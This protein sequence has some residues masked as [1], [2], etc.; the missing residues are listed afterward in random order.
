[1][2]LFPP[3]G[4]I[5][6]P[7]ISFQS[8]V[9]IFPRIIASYFSLFPFTKSCSCPDFSFHKQ[10]SFS[11]LEI[12]HNLLNS[13][14]GLSFKVSSRHQ[15]QSLDN[16]LVLII[17]CMIRRTVSVLACLATVLHYLSD[18]TNYISVNYFIF[19][20]YIHYTSAV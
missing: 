3:S 15:D 9:I 14:S 17:F 6:P 2:I 16:F 1:M 11:H 5:Y 18:S 12:F 7:A 20:Y 4:L 19:I 13:Q 10:S 8:P